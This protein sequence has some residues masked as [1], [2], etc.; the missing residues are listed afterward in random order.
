[1]DRV[2]VQEGLQEF[3]RLINPNKVRSWATLARSIIEVDGWMDGWVNG[4]VGW[5][6]GGWMHARTNGEMEG[7][8]DRQDKLTDTCVGK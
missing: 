7:R 1:M 5:W 6:L 3:Y 2:L 4:W 8:T